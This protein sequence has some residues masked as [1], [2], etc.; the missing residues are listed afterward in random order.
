[1][2]KIFEVNE[3]Q[4]ELERY[5]QTKNISLQAW[6]ASDEYI[7][8]YFNEQNFPDNISVLILNDTFGALTVALNKYKVTVFADSFL[9]VCGIENNLENNEIFSE[10]IKIIDD[11]DNLDE[12]YDVV[13]IKIPKLLT[14]LEYELS[15]LQKIKTDFVLIGGGM[16]RNIHNSNINLFEKYCQKVTTTKARKKARLI[17]A[18]SQKEAIETNKFPLS[19][20]FNNWNIVNYANVFSNQKLDIGTRFFLE[21]FPNFELSPKTI[22][23]LGCGNGILALYAASKY[24]DSE[25]ICVDSSYMAIKSAKETFQKNGFVNEEKYQF[26]VEDGLKAMSDNS[27]DVVVCNP[28]FHNEF[29]VTTEIADAMFMQAGKALNEDGELWIVA[30]N[31]LKYNLMLKRYFEKVELIKSSPKFVIVKASKPS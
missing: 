2:K 25:I 28:P 30:N 11:L 15:V 24:P 19:Y 31:N 22:V 27:L 21:N 26:L 4:F 14:F 17:L 13:L 5:P 12:N 10:E 6:D 20:E 23:D 16:T 3:Q 7:I 1:M 29:V 9:S 8:D 18:N